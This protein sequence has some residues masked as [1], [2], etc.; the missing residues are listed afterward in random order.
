MIFR[1]MT[2]DIEFIWTTTCLTNLAYIMML[3]GFHFSS[4]YRYIYFV[5]HRYII[6][7]VEIFKVHLLRPANLFPRFMFT[8]T[9]T[10][11]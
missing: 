6:I 1:R 8:D 10:N 11:S 4:L 9:R 2:K 5:N 3:L 7:E